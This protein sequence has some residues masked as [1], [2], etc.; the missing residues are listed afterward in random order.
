MF[1][2]SIK[3]T[4]TFESRPDGGLR[5]WSD[6]V[7]GLVL[8]HSDVDGILADVKTAVETILSYRLNAKIV[9]GPLINRREALED[10]GIVA[11]LR[12]VPG[13]KEYVARCH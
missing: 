10:N 13:P 3:V 4:V 12:F 11:P 1:D 7:P 6:D 8:S 9:V 2:R 5:V